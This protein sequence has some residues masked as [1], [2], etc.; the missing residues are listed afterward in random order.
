MRNVDSEIE[1]ARTTAGLSRVKVSSA[2]DRSEEWLRLVERGK[3]RVS[4][5]TAELILRT[6]AELVELRKVESASRADLFA[7]RRLP[8]RLAQPEK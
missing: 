6:I 4:S 5:E 3:T 7:D 1:V 2:I 8:R